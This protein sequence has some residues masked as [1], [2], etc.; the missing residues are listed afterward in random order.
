MVKA[1]KKDTH[2]PEMVRQRYKGKAVAD[3][4]SDTSSSDSDGDFADRHE[5]LA[6]RRQIAELR[7]K[8]L[9]G[10]QVNDV[11]RQVPVRI[12][13]GVENGN[14]AGLWIDTFMVFSYL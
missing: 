12:G 4:S 1:L 9:D 11:G 5:M 14:N 8:T 3:D 2:I 13:D 7:V 10:N 6:C